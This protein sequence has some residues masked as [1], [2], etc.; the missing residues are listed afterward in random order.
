MKSILIGDNGNNLY[1]CHND[2]ILLYN[3]F[4][5]Y[6]I[7]LYFFNDISFEKIKMNIKKNLLII[8]YFSGHS[9]NNG[10]II[11]NNKLYSSKSILTFLNNLKSNLNVI[12]IIDSCYSETFICKD[13]FKYINNI[14]Y[15]VSC[16]KNQTSKE[17]IVDYDEKYYKYYNI[18]KS[19]KLVH[20]IFTYYLCKLFYKYKFDIEKIKNHPYWNIMEEKYQQKFIYVEIK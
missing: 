18:K 11:I 5:E 1:G 2:V 20:S 10:N 12:F 14:K 8:F 6:N 17:I 3:F 19:N 7:P 13:N 9:I 4:F 15:L 16:S